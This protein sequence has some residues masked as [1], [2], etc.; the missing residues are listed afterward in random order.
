MA[1]L[2]TSIEFTSFKSSHRG[3]VPVLIEGEV[4]YRIFQQRRCHKGRLAGA[5]TKKELHKY[6][7]HKVG[8]YTLHAPYSK[9]CL[10]LNCGL[11]FALAN[12][13]KMESRK[14]KERRDEQ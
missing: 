8:E 7:R 1:H 11:L 13:S 4:V 12:Q 6:V 3:D 14:P 5:H 9:F 10:D 2:F